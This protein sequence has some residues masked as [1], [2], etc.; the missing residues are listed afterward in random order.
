MLSDIQLGEASNL[1]NSQDQLPT[2]YFKNSQSFEECWMFHDGLNIDEARFGQV[3]KVE[4][5]ADLK[6]FLKTM[7]KCFQKNDPQNPYGELGKY[8]KTAED[9]WLENF[10]TDRLQYFIIYKKKQPVAVAS[11]TTFNKLGYISNVGSLKEVRGEGFGKL[12]TLYCVR[13]SVDRGNS[14]HFLGT[15]EGNYPY[16]FYK[17]LG[18]ENKFRAISWK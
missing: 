10:A 15:E 16:E 1:F 5:K 13:K 14:L 8:L 17:R 12:A 6:I 3:K 7:N 11:L 9:H 2:N 4:T 18:F